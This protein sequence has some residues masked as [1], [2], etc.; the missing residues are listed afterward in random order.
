MVESLQSR[1]QAG[2][3]PY[4]YCQRLSGF[5]APWLTTTAIKESPP[6]KL[7]RIHAAMIIAATFAGSSAVAE[8]VP[9]QKQAG[10]EPAGNICSGFGPQTPR[11]IDNKLGEN[12][13]RFSL[14]PSYRELNLCNIHFHNSAEHKAR[15]FSI[16]ASADGHGHG[17]GY[18]CAISRSL[19]SEELK[20][21]AQPICA[22][23]KPGDTIEVHWVHSSCDVKPGKSLGACLSET[24][25]NPDLRVETQVFTLVNDTS[26]LDFNSFSNAGNRV[27]GFYQAASLPKD[28]GTPVEFPGS[29]TGPSFNSQQCSP[30]QVSW[31]VRPECAKLDIN[32]LGAWCKDNVFEENHAHGVR[33]LVTDPKL[34]SEIP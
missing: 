13:R 4:R 16:P 17:G 29:T 8:S 1:V 2:R 24:C 10:T 31:S 33:A 15:A 7:N 19:S 11:D 25:A 14:A 23:L 34:L 26:A 20:A 28:T 22:G 21:P 5:E 3:I 12:P 6:M 27:N 18:Q 9:D 32:S 30:L